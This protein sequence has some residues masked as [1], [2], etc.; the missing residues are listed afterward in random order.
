[1]DDRSSELAETLCQ[2]EGKTLTEASGEVSRAINIF[3]YYASKAVDYGGDH[4]PT[5]T[6]D[7]NSTQ[8]VN[9]WA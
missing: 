9:Q 7:Q 8:Y 6:T 4:K 2:E 1:M 5:T 3:Y